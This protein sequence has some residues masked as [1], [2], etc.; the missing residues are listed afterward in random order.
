MSTLRCLNTP[1]SMEYFIIVGHKFK[2][3]ADLAWKVGMFWFSSYFRKHI[4]QSTFQ[5]VNI[6]GGFFGLVL[7]FFFM[8]HL[9]TIRKNICNL[10]L[11]QT[12]QVKR[13]IPSWACQESAYSGQNMSCGESR[14]GMLLAHTCRS[15]SWGASNTVLF[16]SEGSLCACPPWSHSKGL[17]LLFAVNGC[18]EGSAWSPSALNTFIETL[19][20]MLSK[21]S[22]VTS[23]TIW[24]TWDFV[25]VRRMGY[26]LWRLWQPGVAQCEYFSTNPV[27]LNWNDAY[28][29]NLGCSFF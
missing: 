4:R 3:S 9:G 22:P 5:A 17:R 24:I 23:S 25:R 11:H 16:G 14:G 15:V 8:A 26:R 12:T 21:W 13:L 10:S 29:M 6:S 2:Y 20:R 18:G 27:V 7:F 19:V 28:F 1:K